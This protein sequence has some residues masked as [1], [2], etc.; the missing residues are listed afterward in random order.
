MQNKILNINVDYRL[1]LLLVIIGISVLSKNTFSQTGCNFAAG[2]AASAATCS[3]QSISRGAGEYS[4]LSLTSGVVYVFTFTNNPQS[5]GI[6]INGTQF[7]T[8]PKSY[9]ATSTSTHTV[10]P[11]RNS[12]TWNSTSA[13]IAYKIETPSGVTASASPTTVCNGNNITLTGGATN[14]TYGSAVVWAWNGPNSYTSSNEDPAAFA[15]STSA[16]GTYSLTVSNGSCS[17]TATTSAVT[18]TSLPTTQASNFTY[19]A[20]G[21]T[22]MTL[23]WTRGNGANVMIIAKSGSAPTDPTS[24]TSYNANAAYGSG[25]AA[26]GGYVVYNGTGTS[27]NLTGLSAGTTY[28][29]TAY[30]YNGSGCYNLTELSGNQATCSAPG[31][32]A[33]SLTTSTVTT[34][35]TTVGWTRGNGSRVLVIAKAGGA[36]TDPT[37]GTTYTANSAYTSGTSVGGGYAVY[38]GTGTSVTLTGLSAGTTYHYAVY[39]YN[40]PTACYNTTEL[41]GSQATCSTPGTQATSFTYTT[42]ATTSMTLGWTRGNGSKVLI[43]ARAGSAVA[44]D[45]TDGF[46]YTA[47]AAYSSG[48]AIGSAYVVYD[49]T[50][51]SVNLTG[52][53]AGTTYHFAAYEY[54]TITACYN[55]TELAGSQATCS[56]PGT[57][58][59]NFAYSAI[60][61][62][63]MTLDWTRGN[64]G[65]VLVLAR[66]GSAVAT[67]P[68]DGTSYTAN[69]AYSSGSAIGSA[70]VVYDG[71]GTSVNLTG[72]SAGTTYHFAA[73]EYN[74]PTGCYNGTELAGSQATCTGPA[75]Q[76]TS[77]TSSSIATT[78]MIIGWS[79]GDGARVLVIAKAGSAPTDPSNGVTYTANAAYGSGTSVGGGYAVYDGTGTSVALT[80][81]SAGTTYYFAVYEY[82]TPTACYNLTELTGS[83]C[84]GP[85]SQATTFTYN[86]ITTTS[87][88]LGWTRGNGTGGVLIIAKAGSAPTDPTSGTNYTGNAAYGSGTSVGGGYAIYKGTG[89]SVAITGLTAATTYHFAAYDFDTGEC[90]NLAQLTGSSCTLPSQPSSINSD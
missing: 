21:I 82:N 13:V 30:E 16:A 32:Q 85:S 76:A 15:S 18:V 22:T 49:G 59:T 20:I 14:T 52:L 69:A 2:A 6:C 79:R 39:E 34:T 63:T 64:G 88:T 53:S 42:V 23:G 7:T 36:P 75:S 71:T 24:A 81:L 61:T 83:T 38:D 80:G 45:P 87:L 55:A 68:T 11:Y 12:G 66:A 17:V 74:S 50:G 9:T 57:Q 29:F 35:S 43:L 51:T 72:L 8:S 41:T 26:G 48:D 67:D 90:Y 28:Y 89:T 44:T 19:S 56:T 40:T 65:K 33:T 10:V 1:K 3:N 86:T 54:N 73:Y 37:N 25:D 60:G 78:S 58:A 4:T 27:V 77:Y 46:T 47:N 31:T 70:Y 62:T 5:N 84:T